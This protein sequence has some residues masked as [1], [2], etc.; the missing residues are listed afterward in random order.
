MN[1]Y[2]SARQ[3]KI[4]NL[5]EVARAAG[6]KYYD[7]GEP[8]IRGHIAVRL[9]S[10]GNCRE[11]SKIAALA[12]SRSHPARDSAKRVA[13]ARILRASRPDIQEKHR[14]SAKAW[15]K[16]NPARC[17]ARVRARWAQLQKAVPKWADLDVIRKIY[18]IANELGKHVDHIVPVKSALV[19]GLHCEDNLQFLTQK[20]NSSKSNRWWPD[21]P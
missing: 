2:L 13:R 1:K 17:A 12:Y 10:T 7:T 15:A 9:I 21:M 14:Q 20:E 6:S 4:G 8:C 11:C 19:C 5:I 18:E 3:I 16:K